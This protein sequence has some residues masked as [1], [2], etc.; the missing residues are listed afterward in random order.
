MT[1]AFQGVGAVGRQIVQPASRSL[2]QV[3]FR[4]QVLR[5]WLCRPHILDGDLPGGD[6][7]IRAGKGKNAF[8]AT[9][10]HY[11]IID[12]IEGIAD[13]SAS[14]R[15]A[16]QAGAS[17]VSVSAE[18]SRRGR[19]GPVERKNNHGPSVALI[20][21]EVQVAHHSTHYADLDQAIRALLGV[22][23]RSFAA[24]QLTEVHDY[25]D[26]REYGRVLATIASVVVDDRIPIRPETVRQVDAL[27]ASMKMT[28]DRVMLRLHAYAG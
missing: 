10:T 1:V 5:K 4:A 15:S 19:D 6:Q 27:A 21:L 23:E 8:S 24:D 18:A 17:G 28:G 12:V 2:D 14:T 7:T 9:R 13:D 26:H 22:L 3:T 20:P 16:G 11:E 25:L